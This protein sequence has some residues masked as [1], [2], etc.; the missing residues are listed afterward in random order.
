MGISEDLLNTDFQECFEQ[1][2]HYDDAFQSGLQFTYGGVIGLSGLLGTL[3]QIKGADT[4]RTVTPVLVLSWLAGF[5]MVMFLAKNRVYF[6][7]VARYVNQIRDFYLRE[8]HGK[9]EDHTNFY[10]NREF[11]PL[12]DP[13]STQAFQIYLACALDSFLFAAVVVAMI[14]LWE[15][16]HGGTPGVDW[17]WGPLALLVCF[18]AELAFIILYWSQASRSKP[19]ESEIQRFRELVDRLTASV[20]EKDRKNIREELAKLTFGR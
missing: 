6:A 14:A 9:F 16:S 12:F 19:S 3:L 18:I 10:R 7:K 20:D 11:P 8:S 15:L 4:L 13:G 17:F 2:R 1:M 5:L